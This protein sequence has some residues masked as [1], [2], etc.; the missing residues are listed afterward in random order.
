[1]LRAESIQCPRCGAPL[2]LPSGATAVICAYCNASIRVELPVAGAA[3]A[4]PTLTMQAIAPDVVEQV[5]QLVLAGKRPD[6][7]AL[8]AEHAK[9]ERPAAEKAID[10]LLTPL[11]LSMTRR[12]PINAFGFF[13][14]AVILGAC[15]AGLWWSVPRVPV[16]VGYLLLA[17]LCALV[18]GWHVWWFVPKAIS[19]GVGMWGSEGRAAILKRVVL[20]PGFRTGGTLVAVVMRVEPV[21]GGAPFVDEETML[22]R[23]ESLSKLEPG[24]V[25]RVRFDGGRD[26]R[27][28]P[29]SPIEVVG[30]VRIEP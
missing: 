22:V 9:L 23:D 26:R 28:F 7:I 19:T 10:G 30:N 4:R 20:K 17:L 18:A 1:M 16:N 14:V 21:G 2:P 12:A 15:V 5:K 3:G 24:S 29:I 13:L 11:L 8:Y 25:I 6:A 27:V